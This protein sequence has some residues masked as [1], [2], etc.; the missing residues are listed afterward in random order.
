LFLDLE[1]LGARIL[2]VGGGFISSEF[3]HIAAR[4]A[5]PRSS[6]TEARSE[7][8]RKWERFDPHWDLAQ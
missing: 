3:A 6:S 8:E 4:A 2:F 5:A 1:A 7:T